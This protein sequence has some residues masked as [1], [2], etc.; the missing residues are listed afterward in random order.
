MTDKNIKIE[1]W[2]ELL[3]LEAEYKWYQSKLLEGRFADIA[4]LKGCKSL[5]SRLKSRIK[6]VDKS[7]RSDIKNR[8]KKYEEL[9]KQVEKAERSDERS[10][11]R[12]LFKPFASTIN[13]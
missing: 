1:Y 4:E 8:L 6:F 13:Y 3:P 5:P 7:A 12:G 11:T 10:S 9:A 2:K